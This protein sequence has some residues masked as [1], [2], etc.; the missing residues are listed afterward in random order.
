MFEIM[1]V[2]GVFAVLLGAALI[3]EGLTAIIQHR[4]SKRR[5]FR[6]IRRF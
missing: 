6:R 1:I 4:D 5:M 3:G 2:S